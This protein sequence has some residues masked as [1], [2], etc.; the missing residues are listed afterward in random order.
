MRA[1]IGDQLIVYGLHVDEPGRDGGNPR[2]AWQGRRAAICRPLG[3]TTG[4]RPCSFRTTD[5][6]V[7]HFEHSGTDATCSIQIVDLQRQPT[8]VVRGHV[9]TLGSPSSS[10][11]RSQRSCAQW[12]KPVPYRKDLPSP[13]TSR[14][15]TALTSK[16]ASRSRRHYGPYARRAGRAVRAPRWTRPPRHTHG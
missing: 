10:Q 15:P 14:R 12:E 4:T 11:Q 9:D 2:G 8:A 16:P 6:T 7:H 13:V 3:P 1:S 5:A